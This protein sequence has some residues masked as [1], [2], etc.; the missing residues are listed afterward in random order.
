MG[1]QQRKQEKYNLLKEEEGDAKIFQFGLNLGVG[2]NIDKFYVGYTFQPDLS[3]YQKEGG[4]KIKT[5]NNYVTV[6]INF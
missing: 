5:I 2:V 1:A 3:P 6:G 4:L